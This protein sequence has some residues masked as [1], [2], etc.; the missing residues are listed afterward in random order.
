LINHIHKSFSFGNDIGTAEE[1]LQP[2]N[3]APHCPR[4]Q[5][6][7]SKDAEQKEAEDKQYKL[8]FKA[9]FDAV[10]KHKQ[11]LEV[12]TGNAYASPK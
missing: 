12:N 4:L 9:E 5:T 7:I 10:M 2:Y 6:S 11:S 1:E 8:E 3:M